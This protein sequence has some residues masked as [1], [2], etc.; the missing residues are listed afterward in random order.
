MNVVQAPFSRSESL[1]ATA[2]AVLQG[3]TRAV[4]DFILQAGPTVLRVVRQ[5]LGTYH[6][7]VEDVAQ[8]A[9]LSAL[10]SL[11]RFR[12]ECSVSH[13]V[14]RVAAL[15]AMNARRRLELR[16]RLTPGTTEPD[17]VPGGGDSP[18][19]ETACSRHRQ[20]FLRL[21]EELPAA[22]SEV[23]LLH[24]VLGYTVAE[25]AEA[26]GVPLNTVRSRLIA[27][28]AQMRQHWQEHPELVELAQGASS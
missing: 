20:A 24:V 26:M 4:E 23:M 1:T 25:T 8:D 3:E 19:T 10:D 2:R 13:F 22:Q 17:E 6:P 15:T 9:L 18:F 7:D 5:I 27:A 12:W 16:E 11:P 21:L 14:W 28:K